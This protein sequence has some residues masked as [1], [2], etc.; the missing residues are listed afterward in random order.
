MEDI[1]D[2]KLETREILAPIPLAIYPLMI[3][4]CIYLVGVLCK[5]QAWPYGTQIVTTG[6]FS[7]VITGVFS[8]KAFKAK[9]D[10]YLN[11]YYFF[12]LL[13]GF[14]KIIMLLFA[15]YNSPLRIALNFGEMFFI[16]GVALTLIRYFTLR[17]PQT[18]SLNIIRYPLMFVA[19]IWII[20]FF[21]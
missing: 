9:N 14:S 20:G 18:T 12:F 4:V 11:L 13:G 2:E 10:F 8:F 21:F 1:L 6:I 5:I 7:I 17:R 3:A 16:I 15:V 19:P